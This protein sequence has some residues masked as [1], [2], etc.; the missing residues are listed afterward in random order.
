MVR[1]AEAL[2]LYTSGLTYTQI[3]EQMGWRSKS[4]SHQ[5]VRRALADQYRL[6]QA[7]AIRVEE[8]RLDMLTRAFTRILA[9]Q[10]DDGLVIQA[11]L[12]L[13]RVSESRR[14]LLGLD[15]PARRRV[16]VIT[17]D[18]IDSAIKQLQDE[19]AA[20]APETYRQTSNRP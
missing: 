9:G 17:E 3:A 19:L 5:A 1:D 16:D 11:G 7:E 4:A 6:P 12:A 20:G 14:K 10:G 13:M 2:R 8:Q 15:A 18:V